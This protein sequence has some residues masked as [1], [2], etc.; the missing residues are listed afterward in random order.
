MWTL[1]KQAPLSEHQLS[2]IYLVDG[3][4]TLQRASTKKSR[5]TLCGVISRAFGS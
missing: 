3:D 5:E 1:R 4:G 2:H